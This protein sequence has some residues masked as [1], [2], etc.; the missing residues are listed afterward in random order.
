MRLPAMNMPD[1]AISTV[2]PEISTAWPEVDAARSSDGARPPSRRALLAFAPEVEERVVDADG[3]ADEQDH[4]RGRLVVAGVE[5]RDGREQAERSEHGR[6]REQHREPGRDE[7]RRRRRA[8]SASV[9]G[10]VSRSAMRE[11][12]L[13]CLSIW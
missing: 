6:E 5:W 11:V 3:H 7:R 1:I 4:A 12:L 9:I 13:N 2:A 10:I 8:G